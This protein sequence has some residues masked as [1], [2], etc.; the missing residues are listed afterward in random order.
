MNHTWSVRRVPAANDRLQMTYL[1][2][3]EMTLSK[4]HE[5]AA[6]DKCGHFKGR[7]VTAGGRLMKREE[8]AGT[9]DRQRRFICRVRVHYFEP[10]I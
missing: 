8:G 9:K 1:A 6:D 10:A 4:T 5:C 3:N 2:L 7:R